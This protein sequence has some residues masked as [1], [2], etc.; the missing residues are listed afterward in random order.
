MNKKSDK[1]YP[2]K[3]GI[4]IDIGTSFINS[5]TMVDEQVKIR[6]QR[7]AFFDVENDKF[8]RN[9]L[10]QNGTSYIISEDE[11]LLYVV[12]QE[13]LN[14][15]NVFKKEVRRPLRAGVIS[16]REPE[17]LKM[18]KMILKNVLGEPLEPGEICKFSVPAPPVDADYN[19]VYHENVLKSFVESFGFKAEP[20]NE[21]RALGYAELSEQNFTGL[22]LS[23]GAGM[24]NASLLF[25]GSPAV[26]FSVSRSGDWIDENSANAIGERAAKMTAVK[27]AG[28]DLLSP[29]NRHEEALVI[30]YK[31]LISYVVK[32]FERKLSTGDGIPEFPQPI[33]VVLGGGT[34]LPKSFDVVFKQE[35]EKV[36]M[37][38]SIK[39]VKLASDQMF[40][41]AKG[42]LY[43]AISE[44]DEEE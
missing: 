14:F 3:M 23:F 10:K 16:T 28:I 8:A 30:F 6:S 20:I 33:T 40:A 39:E 26:E 37:P 32:Q 38:F 44:Y 27:E 21:A 43:S 17:A 9:M 7:D 12:G 11:K 1:Q 24:V 29:K 31:S 22:S 41:V 18:I 4:G 13:A 36:K 15:A 2:R 5:A 42:C 34:S 25:H 19:V 35:L